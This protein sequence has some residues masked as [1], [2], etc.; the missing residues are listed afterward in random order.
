LDHAEEPGNTGRLIRLATTAAVVSACVLIVAKG[1]AFLVTNSVSVLASFADSALDLLASVVSFMAVRHALVPADNQ[2]RFGHGKAEPLSALAQG[3]F[4]A[5]SA[6]LLIAEAGSRFSSDAQVRSGELGIAVTLF[7]IILT[8]VLVTFQRHVVRQTG[9]LAIDADSL[10]YSGDLLLNLSVIAALFF[11]TYTTLQWADPV[12]AA[13][14]A[15]YLLYNA[16]RIAKSS[17]NQLMDHELNESDR[18]LI[19]EIAMKHPKVKGVHE[20]RTRSSGLNTFM[21]LHLVLDPELSL[22]EAHRV[23]DQVEQALTRDFANADII[24]HQD[25]EGVEEYHP[26]V[27]AGLL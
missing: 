3:A 12:I 11:S 5:G 9:S 8:L 24:I 15:V 23:S 10:H 27:G 22:I 17:I 13:L 25:P 7:A 6:V 18:S 14:I 19:I 1:G 16:W 26:P 2:H 4:V 20:L 21:Q